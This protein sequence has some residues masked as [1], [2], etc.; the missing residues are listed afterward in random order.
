MDANFAG[1]C[2]NVNNFIKDR[3]FTS[4]R[5]GYPIKIYL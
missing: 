4:D 5:R 3:I 1:L 2:V